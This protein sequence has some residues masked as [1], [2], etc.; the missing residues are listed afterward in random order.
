[1]QWVLMGFDFC[2]GIVSSLVIAVGGQLLGI[3]PLHWLNIVYSGSVFTLILIM[4]HRLVFSALILHP[5]QRLIQMAKFSGKESFS[6]NL[7][8]I[9]I[10]ELY[11]LAQLLDSMTRY[12]ENLAQRSNESL[13]RGGWL[14]TTPRSE[15][16]IIGKVFQRFN[17][18]L[19]AGDNY[20]SEINKRRLF[21]EIPEVLQG[22]KLGASLSVMTMD[23]RTIIAKLRKEAHNISLA[24]AKVVAMSQQ[25]SRNANTETQAVESISSSIQQVAANLREVMQNIK[26]QGDSLD[27]TFADIE[28]MLA[29]IDNV[30]ES[31]EHLSSL[32]EE[33][34][35]SVSKIHEFM[36]EIEKHAHSLA[37]ISETVSTEAQN[38][39]Q[40][41]G[42]VIEG[43]QTIKRTV[44][45]AAKAIRRLGDESER[46]GEILGVINDVAEQTNLLALNASIIAA[47]A[48][49]HGRGFTVVAGEIKELAERTK[50]ST[51]EIEQIIRSLQAEVV[52]G[53]VAMK[54]CLEAV[55]AGVELANQSGEV[56]QKIV[57]SIQGAR[58]MASMLAQATVTQ[59][60]NSQQVNYATDQITQK[61]EELYATA[62]NQTK[63][64][65]HLS[66]MANILKEVTQHIDQSAIT[67]LQETENIAG[68]IEEIQKLVQANAKIVHQ[69]AASSDELGELESN[70]ADSMGQFHVT[71]Q[72]LPPNFDQSQP[73]IAFVRRAPQLFFDDVCAGVQNMSSTKRFQ[74][75]IL[76]SQADP[77]VQ[78]ENVNWLLQQPW[79]K[80]IIVAPVDE[81]TGTRLLARVMEHGMPIVVLDAY[82]KNV[83]V[84]VVSD[85]RRGG[86]YAAEMLGEGIAEGDLVLVYGFRIVNVINH[87][88]DGFFEKAKSYHWKVVEIFSF[89]N[90]IKQAKMGIM[91][92][93]NLFPNAKGVFLTNETLVLA[94]LELLREGKID[95][96]TLCAVGFDMA[97]EI[98]RAI[99]DGH[100]LGT[101]VQDPVQLGKIATQELLVLLQQQPSEVPSTPKE[102][103]VPVKKITRQNI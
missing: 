63:D 41:V 29:S 102:V 23:L 79:L 48:G 31:V 99:T 89:D 68:A 80:G 96:R 88:M 26:R 69:L 46:I 82:I 42:E 9:Q 59:T 21:I 44:E 52:Q 97:P 60:K 19:D 66:E 10:R 33:T 5:L 34:F 20:V 94:Y 37:D 58:E 22:T 17:N 86:E 67:Q 30:N 47:Q 62:S 103:L 3:A 51:Q 7:F 35:R 49:E 65:A 8:P 32:A 64:S 24:S 76:D 72:Q 25:G 45:D 84:S 28:N 92:G 77:V 16:D 71:P 95:R 15:N 100:L 56:L 54:H 36:Q 93:L 90:D 75:I 73:T 14:E 53:T 38:G 11:D 98:A 101:V 18:T 40:A 87:R 55:N 27:K 12:V 57:R 85:N 1:M 61:L 6:P 83:G 50:A 2:I 43:I 13:E 91:E 70:L 81:H 78:A 74:S 4:A 39:G